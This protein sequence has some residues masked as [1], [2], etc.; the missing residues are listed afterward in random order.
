MLYIYAT[1]IVALFLGAFFWFIFW[2]GVINVRAAVLSQMEQYDVANST[3]STFEL[4]DTFMNNFWTY[5]L[6]LFVFGLMYW[7]Y[8]YAQRK[9]QPM[10]VSY[11]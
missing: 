6:V 10:V 2:V 11:Q 3:H 5:L 8:H 1:I 9:G 4:A 7:L